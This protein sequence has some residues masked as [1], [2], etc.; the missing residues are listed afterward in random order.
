M[1]TTKQQM[2]SNA[3]FSEV[4]KQKSM[5][6]MLTSDAP[7]AVSEHKQQSQA[8]AP[9]VKVNDLTKNH[10][11]SV[12]VDV[13]HQLTDIPVMGDG[14]IG[15]REEALSGSSHSVKINAGA[16]STKDFSI[17]AQQNVGYDLKQLGRAELIN[18]YDRFTEER[19]IYHLAGAR[20]SYGSKGKD[21]SNLIIP[22]DTNPS[23]KELMVND[24]TPA[25]YGRAIYG[26]DAT[27]I[28]DISAT[29]T[30]DIATLRRVSQN[31]EETHAPI[32][33]VDLSSED[34]P[35]DTEPFYIMYVTPAQWTTLQATASDFNQLV[36]NATTRGN[37]FNHQL[38]KGECLMFDNILVKKYFKPVRFYE[39]DEVI[40]SND[41]K[42]ATTTTE[43][44]A[45]GVN[46][47]RAILVGGQALAIANGKDGVNDG[48]F[49]IFGERIE[50]NRKHRNTLTWVD[51]VSKIRFADKQG[52]INDRGVMTIDTAVSL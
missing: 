42:L 33:P 46:I 36:A 25:T 1:A 15:G 30:L 22:F 4:A 9:I 16:K 13:V 49:T 32:L 5:A 11:D 19:A 2:A 3:I 17:M 14:H 52:Y 26:G 48:N 28:G 8:T 40:V 45:N 10:G 35:M 20:G 12:S 6:N 50:A 23:F 51:G 34:K 39:G 41:N 7:T 21:A 18:Y 43:Q 31:L 44:V 47:D 38:F 37:G 27:S 24:V 29:D